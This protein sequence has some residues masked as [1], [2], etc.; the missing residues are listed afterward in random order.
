MSTKPRNYISTGLHLTRFPQSTIKGHLY[1]A[2]CKYEIDYLCPEKRT[3]SNVLLEYPIQT[4]GHR[5]LSSTQHPL[6]EVMEEKE[7][8]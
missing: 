8:G 5:D 3:I 4:S 6:V 1:P 2:C 7:K